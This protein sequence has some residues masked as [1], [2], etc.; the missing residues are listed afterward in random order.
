MDEFD[1]VEQTVVPMADGA[2]ISVFLYGPTMVDAT[3]E[4]PIV[5]L[6]GNGE[7]HENM[8]ALIEM[9]A[10]ERYVVAID[11]RGHGASSRGSEP[12]SYELM[13]Q[14][15]INVLK[16]FEID[17]VH[18]M[19]FSDGGI[20][21]LLVALT[22]PSR[23][24]SMTIM[25]TNLSP[26]GLQD[27][28]LEH[29][30]ADIEELGPEGDIADG[31]HYPQ[32]ELLRLMLNEPHISPVSLARIGC[33]VAVLVGSHDLVKAEEAMSIAE[34]LPNS[35]LTIVKGCGHDLPNEAPERVLSEAAVAIEEAE[36]L[37]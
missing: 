2:N 1:L 9:V 28:F 12:L 36:G 32:S 6:H 37:L 31:S 35:S 10:P 16:T 29:V 14:D 21:S 3:D 18:L 17:K 19:G 33:P 8:G 24:A 22:D 20:V 26:A 27:S 5:M 13:A 23:V 7:S 30:A 34:A 11:S 4:L 25:G 15:V